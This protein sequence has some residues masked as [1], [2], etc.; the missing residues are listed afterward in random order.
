[1]SNPPPSVFF[2]DFGFEIKIYHNGHRLNEFNVHC[3][4]FTVNNNLTPTPTLTDSL[5]YEFVL[6]KMSTAEELEGTSATSVIPIDKSSAVL[7]SGSFDFQTINDRSAVAGL[8]NFLGNTWSTYRSAPTFD[9]LPEDEKY[10][11]GGIFKT[12]DSQDPNVVLGVVIGKTKIKMSDT[13]TQTLTGNLFL[14]EA[15][16]DGNNWVV[17]LDPSNRFDT[18]SNEETGIYCLLKGTQIL[19]PEGNKPIESLLKGD[20]IYNS[21]EKVKKIKSILYQKVKVDKSK[22]KRDKYKDKYQLKGDSGLILSGGHMVKLDDG[23]HLPINSDRFENVQ[24]DQGE[25]EYYHLELDEYDY[26]IANGVE[27]E[28]LTRNDMEKQVFYKERGINF[29]DLVK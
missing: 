20:E 8:K 5:Y 22:K 19:T 11:P 3:T 26:F 23:Y 4:D 2:N 13:N 9:V 21:S 14:I 24:E 29:G 6:F 28:S 7:A 10:V 27:V 25:N 16:R 1:M 17:D 12:A 18:G 15:T